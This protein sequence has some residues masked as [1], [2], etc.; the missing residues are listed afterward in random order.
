MK[1]APNDEWRI[2][3]VSEAK[4][5]GKDIENIKKG[6]Q[7]G[8]ADNQDLMAAEM[9]LKGRIKTYQKLLILCLPNLTF[10]MFVF[11]RFKFLDKN[12]FH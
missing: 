1:P 10:L 12:N 9:L 11:G 7:V 8:T 4:H 6:L 5:Q 3:L 2:V